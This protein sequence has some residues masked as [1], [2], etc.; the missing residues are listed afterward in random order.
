MSAVTAEPMVVRS[1]VVTVSGLSFCGLSMVRSG[2]VVIVPRFAART[3]LW[4]SQWIAVAGSPVD[5]LRSHAAV[6]PTL[7]A[8]ARS[9]PQKKRA[10]C[11]ARLAR[12]GRIVGSG[13]FADHD[14]LDRGFDVGVQVHDDFVL[15][16]AAQ[17]AFAQHDFRLLDLVAGLGQRLGDVARADRAVQLA[18]G[19]GVGGDGDLDAFQR[20]PCGLRRLPARPWPWLRTRRAWLRTR[21]GWR[22]WP[23]RPCPAGPGSCG[24]SPA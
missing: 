23:A 2:I 13:G 19:R 15:A 21:R 6:M 10:P 18:F 8:P 5:A 17:R 7:R 12:S 1:S 3:S 22:R 20:R 14:D 16:G 9:R 4:I 11:G 24:R